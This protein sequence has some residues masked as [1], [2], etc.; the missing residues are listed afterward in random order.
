[1]I[2][3]ATASAHAVAAP[4]ARNRV[5]EAAASGERIRGIHLTFA[6]P[7]VIEVL[8]SANL[9]FVYI[10]GEHG[11]FDWRDVE[12]ACITAERHDLT[13]IARI[14]DLSSATI[15]RFLDR[16]VR[17]T[18]AAACR[19]R[20]RRAD[21]D[22]RRLFRARGKP[23]VRRGAARVRA[24]HRPPAHVHAG[25]QRRDLG[26]RHDR[27]PARPRRCRRRRRAASSRLPE[28]RA[29]SISPSRWGVRRPAHAEVRGRRRELHRAHSWRGKTCAR[30]LHELRVDQRCPHHRCPAAARSG[31]AG[32][33]QGHP[34][35]PAVRHIDDSIRRRSR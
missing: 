1:M 7:S 11:C 33:A 24:A 12:A 15:T 16:G 20:R 5:K 6:A 31:I 29:C 3:E 18:G 13:P 26:V 27:E 35:E 2:R 21:G 4:G 34:T 17:G 23:L 19:V 9:H 14:P 10:D 25:M 22:R 8:A 32:L 30:G 28:L